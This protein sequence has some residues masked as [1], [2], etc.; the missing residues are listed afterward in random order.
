MDFVSS[1]DEIILKA[2]SKKKMYFVSSE[3]E[4]HEAE[5]RKQQRVPMEVHIMGIVSSFFKN[6]IILKILSFFRTILIG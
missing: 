6:K 3:D 4:I 5:S 2:K 1:E